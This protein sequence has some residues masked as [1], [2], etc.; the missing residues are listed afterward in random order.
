MKERRG[1]RG[2][3]VIELLTVMAVILLLAALLL[4]ALGRVKAK[5]KDVTCLN[6]LKQWGLATHLFTV[7]NNDF[8]PADGVPNPLPTS[9]NSGWYVDLP[10][11][12][13]LPK[14][15]EMPWHTNPAVDP[16]RSTWICPANS[17]RSN[18]KNLF[19]YCLNQYVNGTGSNNQPTKISSLMGPSSLVWLFDT[20]N[21]PAVGYW[22]YVHTNVHHGGAQFL[23]IDGHVV[24]W[25]SQEFWLVPENKAR[26]NNPAIR[27]IP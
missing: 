17:R 3:S 9:T 11:E 19:H 25:R 10:P 2:F 23:Y 1:N 7:D 15:H 12:I 4:P 24:G 6:N 27:W 5:G 13:G 18:G 8:L 26:T 14:Y 22:S 20:K 16:G 21:L